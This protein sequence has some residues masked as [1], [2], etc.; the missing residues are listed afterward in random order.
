MNDWKDSTHFRT[1][2]L[3]QLPNIADA[4]LLE[5]SE[6]AAMAFFQPWQFVSN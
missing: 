5:Q 3:F 1:A 4:P 6:H 2:F